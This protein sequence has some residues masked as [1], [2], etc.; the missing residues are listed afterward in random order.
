VGGSH[1]KRR[2]VGKDLL[3][4]VD[5]RQASSSAILYAPVV[6]S[7][8]SKRHFA[9]MLAPTGWKY[10]SPIIVISDWLK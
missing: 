10:Y 8:W 9:V 1:E 7:V 2:R 3:S 4:A 6:A 5:N